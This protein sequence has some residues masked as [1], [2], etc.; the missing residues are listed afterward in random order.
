[1]SGSLGGEGRERI[2]PAIVELIGLA[3]PDLVVASCDWHPPDHRS[4]KEYGGRWAAHCVQN[5]WGAEIS[6]MV[7][8]RADA[9][10][11]KGMDRDSDQYSAFL[12][13]VPVGALTMKL[14]KFLRDLGVERVIVA[15]LVIEVCVAETA[16]DAKGFGYETLVVPDASAGIEWD[17]SLETLAELMKK[18]IL[19]SAW[20]EV[21]K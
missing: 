6:P 15:G 14:D 8:V 13:D 21:S 7:A 2:P 12:G 18:G 9:L 5:T 20:S 11:K 4:F 19:I 3:K 16:K 10:V 17:S 1:V